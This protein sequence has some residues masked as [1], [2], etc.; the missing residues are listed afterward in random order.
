[1]SPADPSPRES[2]GPIAYM[3]RNGVAANLLMFFIVAAGVVSFTGLVQEAFPVLP[4]NRVEVAVRY[5]GAT[6]GEVEE[7]IVVKIEE[8][9]ATLDGVKEVTAVAAEGVA[10]VMAELVDGADM[11]RTID[12]I[13][14]AV[15]RIETL[16]A[17]AERPEIREMTNRQSMMRLILHGNVPERTLKALAYRTEDE[18]A[19]LPGVSHVET[20]GVR[21]GE[22][23]VE[24]PLRRL[25][26]L[27]LTL[28]DVAA[29]IRAGSI[30]LPAG[31]IE[32][33]DREVRVR[34]GERSY[35]QQ[36]FENIV[37]L[38]RGDGTAV[39]LGD[40]AAVR[41]GLQEADLVNRYQGRRAAFIEVHR[42]AGEQVL[43]VA[44]VVEDYVEHRARASLP[45]GVGIAVWND[46]ADIYTERIGLLLKN[47]ALGLLLVLVG[48]AL[49]LEART[50]VWVAAGIGISTLGAL[51]AMLVFDV[52]IS[53]ISAFAFILAVG[54]IVDDA[55]VVA[56]N[57]H[58]ERRRGLSGARAAIRG[59]QRIQRPLIFAVLTTVAAFAPLLFLPGGI[60]DVMGA[61]PIIM[62]SMIVVSLIE[63]LL[64]LPNHLSHL[65]GPEWTPRHPVGRGLAWIQ[66][67]VD[68]RFRWFTDGPLDR[69]LRLAADRPAVV[70]AGAVGAVILSFSLIP[71]GV[72]GVIFAQG[73]AG[74][75]V[76]ASLEMPAG[77]PAPRTLAV[78]EDLE[79][80]GRRAAARLSR[81]GREDV[82]SAIGGVSLTVGMN[83][84]QGGGGLA[85]EPS[86]N[87]RSNVALV[88]FKMADAAAA[89][90]F[91]AAWRD[92]AGVPPAAQSLNFT[93]ELI[94]LGHPVEAVL[95]HP[96]PDRLTALAGDVVA[97][98]RELQGVFDVRSDHAAGIEEVRVGLRSE[99]HALG[100]TLDDVARQVRAAFFGEEALR[101]QRGRE[102][103]RV[104]VRLPPAERDAMSDVERTWIRTPGGEAVPLDRVASLGLSASPASIRRQ[105]GR[106]IV[107]VTADVDPAVIT[108]GE[109]TAL[110]EGTLLADLAAANPGLTYRFGGAQQQQIESFDALG[111]GFAL[112]AF[113]IYALL[114]IPLAS[115][116]KPLIVMAAIPFGIVG[117]ILGHLVL[118]IDLDINSLMG[119]LGLSGVVVN[120]SLVMIDFINQRLREGTPVR[121]AI[122]DGAKGR[123]RP[124]AITSLTTFLGF[125]PIILETGVHAQFL[126]PFAA[127]MG[128][129]ILFAT[130]F[131]MLVVPALTA[132][133]LRSAGV[134]AA[135]G[136]ADAPPEP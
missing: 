95:S 17:G 108:G 131:L 42:A 110:L 83:A 12:E 128:F 16:P 98:L 82:D 92:E 112:A 6:P 65:P 58:L 8:R 136:G 26:A 132:I 99:A 56:E 7:S 2:R 3:V 35:D 34:T 96:D 43:D 89:Q 84:R 109:A 69:G 97:H 134:S 30:D 101:V 44:R 106:R 9:I 46:D 40:V 72:I 38:S 94:D 14:S 93:A 125:T 119:M 129:G 127:S 13:E 81:Q 60:G 90:E 41:D 22:I 87:P 29:A 74:D 61:V 85:Q 130:G 37:V 25:R 63:S 4:F 28:E 50:A 18:I 71:A 126:V 20:S 86:L 118:R 105:A 133:Q 55:I 123:F 49:F 113:A 80:A 104:Y 78:A 31:S 107:T 32:T 39:R 77:T 70:V 11:G 103:V 102:D 66:A 100:V 88:E 1:M 67:G 47:G 19:A 75:I 120:D 33:R 10:S 23:S 115:Y 114:A 76:T 135:P 68:R 116:A 122:V 62:I 91:L 5:P 51:P 124:I 73:V 45:P 52:S 53:S 15:G 57:V 111:R 48:L 24:V 27:G 79:A 36:D 54:I 117:A 121:E 21:R 59:A 64:V